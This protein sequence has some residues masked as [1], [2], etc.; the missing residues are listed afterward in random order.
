MSQKKTRDMLGRAGIIPLSRAHAIIHDN[1]PGLSLENELLPLEGAL[2]RILSSD[3]ISPENLPTHPRSTMDGYAVKASDTFGASEGMPAYLEITGEVHMGEC[4]EEGPIEGTCFRIATGG[5]LPPGTDSV[6]M[7]EHT[8]NVDERMI[9][10]VKPVASGGNVIGVG[11]DVRSGET[12]LSRGHRLR[13]QDLG[14]LAGLGIDKVMVH[15]KVRTGIISTGDEIVPHGQK[16]TPGKVRDMNAISLM[17]LLQSMDS[18]PTHYGIVADNKEA[19]LT[20]ARK[21]LQENDLV[22]FSGSSSVGTRD[23]GEQVIEELGPPG[24][25]IHGVAVKPGK[26]VIIAMAGNKPIFG[27]PGHPVSATVSFD[28]FVRPMLHHLAGRAKMF[29]PLYRQVEA[30]LKR[31][32][33]SASGRVDYVRVNVQPADNG[34]RFEAQPI[35]GKSSALSTMVKADG[36][37]VINED[38]QG[39]A[40]GEKI[41]V[42][43][44]DT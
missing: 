4:P 36:Y 16:V 3:I 17:G 2:G 43:L 27:L 1:L 32:I 26:P 7:F 29:L 39:V 34:K 12:I 44:F 14:L 41:H 15:R 24:I 11:D 8:V 33:N 18:V 23:L 6:V 42:Q 20:I 5:L 13:P 22:L 37:F 10:I 38:Q 21:A 28:L 9:E 31:N 25:I 30:V 40:A 19:L 35:L